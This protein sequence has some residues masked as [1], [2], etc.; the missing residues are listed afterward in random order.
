MALQL[1]LWRYRPSGPHVSWSIIV[2]VRDFRERSAIVREATWDRSRPDSPVRIRDADLAWNALAPFMD[3]AGGLSP[4]RAADSLGKGD[5]SGLEGTRSF[6][7]VRLEWSGRGPR[8]LASTIA[9]YG[10]FRSLLTR[11]LD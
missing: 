6:A 1:R 2:P 3:T 5:R 9:W 7:H 8:A 4:G 10:R 11:T